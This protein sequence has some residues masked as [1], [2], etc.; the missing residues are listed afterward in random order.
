MP[1]SKDI[2]L[3]KKKPVK[4]AEEE[5]KEIKDDEDAEKEVDDEEVMLSEDIEDALGDDDSL[6]LDDED[7]DPFRDKWEE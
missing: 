7:V 3:K 1:K 4:G 5:E 6:D 2:E